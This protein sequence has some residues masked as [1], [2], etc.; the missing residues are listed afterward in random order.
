MLYLAYLT[1]P[2]LV[3]DVSTWGVLGIGKK[4][5]EKSMVEWICEFGQATLTVLFNIV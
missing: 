3:A 2:F 5:Q 4:L 1:E